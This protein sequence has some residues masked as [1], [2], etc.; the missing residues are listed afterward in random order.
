[1]QSIAESYASRP[2]ARDAPVT[3]KVVPVVAS[4]ASVTAR[5]APVTARK[6]P[7]VSRVAP[8]SESE[9]ERDTPTPN[10]IVWEGTW[11]E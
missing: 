5:D 10:R 2:S 6:T 11:G 4:K 1:M 7:V 9:E 8:V 3:S